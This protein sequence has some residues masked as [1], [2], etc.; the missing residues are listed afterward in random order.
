[1]S[2]VI[3][4]V[5][6]IMLAGTIIVIAGLNYYTVSNTMI[7]QIAMSRVDVLSQVA[8]RTNAM[9]NSI[10]MLSDLYYHDEVLDDF[11]SGG[12]AE[13]QSFTSRLKRLNGTSRSL[14]RISNIDFEY[15]IAMKDGVSYKDGERSEANLYKSMQLELWLRDILDSGDELVWISTSSPD[16]FYG[17]QPVIGAARK[18]ED[19]SGEVAGVFIL[20]VREVLLRETYLD[21]VDNNSI[22]IIDGK[23]KIVS[24]SDEQRIGFMFYNMKRFEEMFHNKS[25]QTILKSG[26]EYLFS[27]HPVK[28]YG[29]TVVEEIPLESILVPL[30]TVRNYIIL[31]SV[32]ALI[33]SILIMRFVSGRITRPLSDLC[34]QLDRVGG[35]DS[36]TF[37]AGG[38]REAERIAVRCNAMMDRI[39]NLMENVK[40]TEHK[41][42]RAEQ[43]FLKMQIQPHFMY[44][45]LFSIKCMVSMGKN[46]ESEKMLESFMG[47][48][49]KMLVTDEELVTV[50]EEAEVL[51]DYVYIQK[52]RS[53][54]VFDFE[55]N[56]DG[57]LLKCRVLQ[58]LLQP[59]VE[60]SIM[61]G[62]SRLNK[63]G[64]IRVDVARKGDDLSI[65]V[66]DNG[67]GMSEEEIERCM[68]G[69][70]DGDSI[71]VKNVLQ[72]I[73]LNY[74]GDYGL[75]ISCREGG[76][77]VV[78]LL[79]PFI[80]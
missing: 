77:T 52:V 8:D 37:T 32:A 42:A 45:T 63:R 79:L 59:L 40:A 75:K 69:A 51:N 7:D 62:V 18:I 71:G 33:V 30:T 68:D 20:A 66:E 53:G 46:A 58:L 67:R 36:V 12:V 61:H 73:Q 35:E 74:G 2:S 17:G 38:W 34:G 16:L 25:Y 56:C 13:D 72:R 54:D 80:S 24:D 31:F 43:K 14:T 23:G 49:R 65:T 27:R 76:G 28:N 15:V 48:L 5:V 1:M 44:N 3:L 47:L 6:V 60:N 9:G 50:A 21:L 4:A 57:E 78:S 39:R 29:W 64:M 70:E 55:V 26:E 11:F 22:Y 19:Q 10:I 41:K